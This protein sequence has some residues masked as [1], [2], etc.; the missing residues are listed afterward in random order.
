MQIALYL[1]D[2]DTP[3]SLTEPG[4]LCL[5]EG[6]GQDW[7]LMEEWPVE[8]PRSGG[9]AGLR[10]AVEKMVFALAPCTV[11]ISSEVRGYVYALLQEQYGF[12]VW[13]SAGS[14]TA[15]L[16]SVEA[17]E[18]ERLTAQAQAEAC[19]CSSQ[20]GCGSCGSARLVAITPPPAVLAEIRPDG[21]RYVDLARALAED[22]RHNSRS[23][24]G[25]ILSATPFRPLTIRMDHPP[26]WLARAVKSLGLE[27]HE[28]RRDG[29]LFITLIQ[30]VAA[31]VAP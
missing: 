9:I 15:M 12:S 10:A 24:L 5:Y 21:S 27:R 16:T 31:E 3:V 30:P 14:V 23:V 28:E 17:G 11:L 22:A 29:A 20:S 4:R 13:K 26:R 25:P 18:I 8:L 7:A 1:D 19:D 6:T 2:T